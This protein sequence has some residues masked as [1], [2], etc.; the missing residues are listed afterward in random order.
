MSKR[1][2]PAAYLDIETR[3]DGPPGVKLMQGHSPMVLAGV[4]HNARPI[5]GMAI[6]GSLMG[7]DEYATRPR[8]VVPKMLKYRRGK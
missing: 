3:Y 5:P 2:K 6:Q 1:R 4:F 7:S 8:K